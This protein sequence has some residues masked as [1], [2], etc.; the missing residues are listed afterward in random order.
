MKFSPNTL[1][2]ILILFYAVGI[3]GM[4]TP[5]RDFFLALTPFHLM[6]SA[7]LFFIGQTKWNWTF[8][9]DAILIICLSFGAEWI[10][11]HTGYLFG[12]YAYGPNL[13]YRFDG[14]PVLIGI[15]WLMLTFGSA[16]L[17]RS[18]QLKGTL[19]VVLGAVLMTGLDWLMEPV[20]IKSGFWHWKSAQIPVYNYICWF[21][22][23]LLFQLW[24]AKR[25]TAS[26]NKVWSALFILMVVFFAI[27]N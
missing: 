12:S 24:I 19:A 27:L 26:V 1:I 21:G 25:K 13:G 10:G 14:I 6:L 8:G 22:L 15:N 11:V 7:L 16:S 2:G 5:Y 23:S 3:I 9:I 20:A 17:V 18:L 4:F